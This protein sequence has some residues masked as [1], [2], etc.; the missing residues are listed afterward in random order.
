MGR[1]KI[2]RNAPCPC[3]SGRKYKECCLRK[4]IEYS[5]DERGGIYKILH[6]PPEFGEIVEEQRRKFAREQGRELGPDDPVFFDAGPLEHLEAEMAE[7]LRKAGIHPALIY[8][9]EKTGMIVS[10]ENKDTFSDADLDEWEAAV[11][12]YFRLHGEPDAG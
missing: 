8:A 7:G 12:E 10:D 3:G 4:G 1:R 5:E 9:F 6:A 2:S 11:D